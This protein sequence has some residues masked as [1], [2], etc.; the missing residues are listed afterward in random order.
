M[1]PETSANNEQP[2][3][4]FDVTHLGLAALLKVTCV[5]TLTTNSTPQHQTEIKPETQKA[6]NCHTDVDF[7]TDS[8]CMGFEKLQEG[9]I[10]SKNAS[11]FPPICDPSMWLG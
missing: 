9:Y 6:F 11:F 7:F 10:L 5:L 8:K 2:L 3:T 1:L 4:S